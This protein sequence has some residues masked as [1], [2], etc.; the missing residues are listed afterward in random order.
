MTIA[1]S[2]LSSGSNGHSEAGSATA[3]DP[4]QAPRP[5]FEVV[6]D[7]AGGFVMG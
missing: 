1:G 7:V 5:E 4:I 6:L 2:G 3:L